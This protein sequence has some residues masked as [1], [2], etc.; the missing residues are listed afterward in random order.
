MRSLRGPRGLPPLGALTPVVGTARSGDALAMPGETE[1]VDA[2]RRL[3]GS[4][5]NQFPLQ[6]GGLR[7]EARY[8]GG[9][10]SHLLLSTPYVGRRTTAADHY[11]GERQALIATRPLC[12]TLRRENAHDRR[13]KDRGVAVEAQTGDPE[14]DAEVYIDS[15][16]RPDVALRVLASPALRTAVRELIRV[17]AAPLDL[18]HDGTIRVRITSFDRLPDDPRWILD[19]LATIAR[20]VP[21]VDPSGD[22]HPRDRWRELQH[23]LGALAIGLLFLVPA[24]IFN[25][26]PDPCYASGDDGTALVCADASCCAPLGLGSAGGV[27]VGVIVAFVLFRAIRGTSSAHVTRWWVA[28]FAFLVSLETG[29]LAAHAAALISR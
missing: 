17:D 4:P 14:L 1:Y 2:L 3:A 18:D 10:S 5:G 19:R 26:L 16:S 12:I 15:P 29:I 24:V 21:A 8:V 28:V 23:V 20:E 7:F 11:R 6:H 9:S 13:A 27:L 22:E 25:V